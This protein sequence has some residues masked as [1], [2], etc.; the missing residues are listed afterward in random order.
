MVDYNNKRT[1]SVQKKS[2]QKNNTRSGA[3]ETKEAKKKR[4][5]AHVFS[6]DS[7]PEATLTDVGLYRNLSLELVF[8]RDKALR[9]RRHVTTMG[10]DVTVAGRNSTSRNPALSVLIFAV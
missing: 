1:S 2:K 5:R 3:C 4:E 7:I 9:R 6:A 8:R 10:T